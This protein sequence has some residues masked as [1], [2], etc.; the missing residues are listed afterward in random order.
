MLV[1]RCNVL[2]VANGDEDLNATVAEAATKTGRGIRKASSSRKTFEILSLGL[3]DVEFGGYFD[4]M[5]GNNN[6]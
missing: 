5:K 3:E 2:F 6:A 1:M 4:R